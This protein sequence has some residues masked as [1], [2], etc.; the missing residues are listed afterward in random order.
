MIFDLKPYDIDLNRFCQH[1]LSTVSRPKCRNYFICTLCLKLMKIEDLSWY[2]FANEWVFE[3]LHYWHC[4]RQGNIYAG[5]ATIPHV[6]LS[7]GDEIAQMVEQRTVEPEDP[8]SNL[9]AVEFFLV[10]LQHVASDRVDKIP[11]KWTYDQI[12]V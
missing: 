6:Q 7:I 5:K 2:F 3:I 4:H 9:A 12:S 1:V 8:G 10:M 11:T